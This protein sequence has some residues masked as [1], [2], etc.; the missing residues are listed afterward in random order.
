MKKTILLLSATIVLTAGISSAAVI[1]DF[2]AEFPTSTLGIGQP[3]SGTETPATGWRYMWNPT[4]AMGTASSYQS[5]VTNTVATFPGFGGTSPMFTNVGNVAFNATGQGNYRFGRIGLTSFH[6][7]IFVTGTDYRG[8]IAYTI[9]AGEAGTIN[10][11]NSSFAKLVNTSSN[12]VGLDIYVNNTLISSLSKNGFNSLSSSDF[13]GS[14]G[15]LSVGDTVYVSIGNNGEANND[16]S[17][18]NFQL[19]SIPEPSAALFGSLGMLALL[20]RRRG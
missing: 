18:I 15:N 20:R 16:A 14:L 19:E 13:N 1:A 17:V 6:P 5:L 7:G 12:G 8:I 4:G 3:F 2:A 10:I 11:T 9:Q